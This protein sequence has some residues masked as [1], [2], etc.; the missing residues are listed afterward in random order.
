M[1]LAAVSMLC[2][3][4]QGNCIWGCGQFALSYSSLR[5][6]L[7]LQILLLM[8]IGALCS[9]SSFGLGYSGL[10]PIFYALVVTQTS[11]FVCLTSSVFSLF[12]FLELY[13][14]SV[15][16]FL[17]ADGC[18][19]AH[20]PL[21]SFVW[22]GTFC[23]LTFVWGLVLLQLTGFISPGLDMLGMFTQ[24]L[25]FTPLLCKLGLLPFGA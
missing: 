21:I 14:I 19:S 22:V 5:F 23:S 8:V 11:T 13:S 20:K 3:I 12:I 9:I 25:L 2:V 6:A 4:S 7:I 15:I 16:G 10:S 17:C 18:E 24:L 1:C